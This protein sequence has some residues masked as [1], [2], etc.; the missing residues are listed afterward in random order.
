VNDRRPLVLLETAE[1]MP[2]GDQIS[3]LAARRRP[4][5]ASSA[6]REAVAATAQQLRDIVPNVLGG[7]VKPSG[8][9]VDV[10]LPEP[11]RGQSP[12]YPGLRPFGRRGWRFALTP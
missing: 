12:S 11:R 10:S 6:D 4:S 1:Q 5:P 8:A 7:E 9:T 3:E 2:P